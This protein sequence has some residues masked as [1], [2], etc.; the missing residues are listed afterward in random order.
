MNVVY[1]VAQVKHWLT[2]VGDLW[3]SKG[4]QVVKSITSRCIKCKHYNGKPFV[5]PS[6]P[7]LPRERVTLDRP[8]KYSAVDFTGAITV[9]NSQTGEE[10]KEY[11]CLF[12][13]LA[14]R[15][16]FL[17]T[18]DSLSAEKFLLCLKRFF[19]RCSVPARMY[20]DNGTN[21][22]AVQKLIEEIKQSPQIRELLNE[23]CLTWQFNV[24]GAP[25]QGGNFERLI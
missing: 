11:I 8:F 19:A 24:P 15:A 13:C 10:G 23:K 2:Y 3:V 1:M 6:P 18:I 25:W 21:F 7:P 20:S 4:R 9:Y 16:V 17:E 5:Y 14:T 22:V 12:S